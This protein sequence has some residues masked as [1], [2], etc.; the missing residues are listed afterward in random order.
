MHTK[1]T[2]DPPGS[3]VPGVMPEP[4]KLHGGAVPRRP[5]AAPPAGDTTEPVSP[6]G[7]RN[8]ASVELAKLLGVI[9]GDKYMVNA[10]PPAWRSTGGD[11][12]G[13]DVAGARSVAAPEA[14]TH[15]PSVPPTKER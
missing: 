1:A 6:P 14:T 13:D 15:E 9:R 7:R 10:Y 11:R 2:I 8:R 4:V 12:V 5:E 3:P